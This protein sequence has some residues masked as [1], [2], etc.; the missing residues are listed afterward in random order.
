[1]QVGNMFRSLLVPLDGSAAA[2]H[3]IPMALSLARRFEATLKI[4][5]V[6]VPAWLPY[7]ED[8]SY[9]A[10]VDRELREQMKVYLDRLIQRLSKVTN[11]PLNSVLLDGLVA[12]AI[13]GHAMESGVGLIVMTTHGRGPV[14]RFWLGSVADALIRQATIPMLCVR[15]GESETDLTQELALG[16]VLIPLDGSQLAEQI[17]EPA[18]ALAAATHAELTLLRVVQQWMTDSDFPNSRSVSGFS[19]GFLEQ[20]EVIDRE[21]RKRAE[22]Y[23]D[24][25]AERLRAR[26]LTVQTRVVSHVRP[27]IAILD[28]ASAHSVDLVALATHGRGGLK[29]LLVGSVA[30]KVLRAAA[31]PVLVYR[32]VGEFVSA[33]D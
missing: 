15:P 28:D 20:L 32:P 10:I 13:N 23:L 26:S 11:V 29:R 4:V 9:D 30:D 25:L 2:E 12:D 17:L 1:M 8:G 7:G 22:G 21:E 14:A 3:A 31:T 5:H 27:A 6:H 24:Q 16:R 33:E 19:P 18:T